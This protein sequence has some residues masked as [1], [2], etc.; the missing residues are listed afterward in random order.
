MI[1]EGL[2]EWGGRGNVKGQCK[3]MFIDNTLIAVINSGGVFVTNDNAKHWEEKNEGITALF[4]PVSTISRVDDY[5]FIG[6]ESYRYGSDGDAIFKAKIS[7]IITSVVDDNNPVEAMAVISPNPANENSKLLFNLEQP[8]KITISIFNDLGIEISRI[9]DNENCNKGQ[10]Q[11]EI[12]SA[13]M[14]TGVYYCV[15]TTD[16]FKETIKF[17]VI[18]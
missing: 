13:D 7:D 12:Y 15:L 5:L 1:S 3:I 2:P 16:Y 18:H 8:S 17:V 11:F 14:P 10:N 4:A 9:V 6:T